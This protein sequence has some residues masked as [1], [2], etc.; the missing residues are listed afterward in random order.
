MSIHSGPPSV[1]VVPGEHVEVAGD[2][3]LL[4]ARA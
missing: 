1:G 2:H 3:E 4:A